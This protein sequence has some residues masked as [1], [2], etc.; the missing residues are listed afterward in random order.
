MSAK[1]E[2]AS[3][4]T[5]EKKG[6]AKFP[7][8]TVVI[9]DS[10]FVGDA[11]AGPWHRQIS[12]LSED[13]IRRFVEQ[14][15]RKTTPGEFA[16]NITIRGLDLRNASLL[17]RFHIGDSLLELTQIGKKCH[18]DAC[19]IF[20]EVGKCVMPKEGVFCRVLR[21]GT[22]KTGDRID[23]VPKVWKFGV[24][25]LSDRASRGDY[26]D[27]SGPRVREW[28]EKF[29]EEKKWRAEFESDVIPDDAQVLHEKLEYLAG[30]GIDVI[31]TSGGTGVG[32]RDITPEVITGFC[33]KIIP[34]IMEAIRMK[35]GRDKPSALLSRSVAGTAGTTL[36]FA[37]PGS[38]RAV[39]EYMEEILKSLSH[40]LFMLHEL[41]VH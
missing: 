20:R 26:P 41:D 37:V 34:G 27:K 23:Y 14:T 25:T 36:V 22:V 11:H 21:G 15:G 3:V 17:D 9:D 29:T 12:L 33:D 7:V 10:G 35:Y 28:L 16:E 19:S 13:S 32:P 31:I 1:I 38:L 24:I 5:S 18:G 40:T 2:V 8:G 30:K 6:T 39:N 4:N